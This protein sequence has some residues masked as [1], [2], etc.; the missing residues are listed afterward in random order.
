MA[1][2][3]HSPDART[4][5]LKF[6]RGQVGLDLS[7]CARVKE[8]APA[9]CASSDPDALLEQALAAPI[10]SPRLRDLAAGARRVVV[11]V[12]DATRPPLARRILPGVLKELGPAARPPREVA[13]LLAAGVHAGV[14]AQIARQVAGDSLPPQIAVFQNDARK[15]ADFVLAGTTRRGT[16]VAVNRLVAE[17]D[18]SVLVGATGFH[19]FAGFGGGRKL[20]VPGA[21]TYETVRANHSL[22]ITG[23]DIDPRCHSGA[24]EGNPVH[25]DMVE[26]LRLIERVFA[27]NLVPDA[28]G[29]IAGVVCGDGVASHLEACSRA[30]AL[31][32]VPIAARCDLAIASAGGHPT[33]M[34]LI[35]AH[36]S[37]DH[38]AA[39]VRDGGVLIAVAECS[40]GAGSETFLPWFDLGGPRAVSA[41]LKADYKLNGQTAL[42]LI[43]KLERIRVILVSALEAGVVRR[44]G[45][46]CARG[47]DEALALAEQYVG[48]DPLT[49]V[50]PNASGILPAVEVQA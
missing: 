21:C 18:L 36:K 50:L 13:I 39:A 17:A 4:W 6:G 23:G 5:A 14:S 34:D 25:E 16:P 42:S 11:L 2:I 44:T 30:R 3:E 43:K 26:G 12:P 46:I 27:V 37:I 24:L 7:R 22:S 48:G 49:Y 40:A 19:Y 33:D 29:Q 10:A 9:P 35:Q 31:L 32:T 45:M 8:V 41:R 20:I 47:L 28:W 38:A 15:G 1:P